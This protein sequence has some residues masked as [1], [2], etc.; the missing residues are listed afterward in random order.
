MVASGTVFGWWV[1]EQQS[2]DGKRAVQS[3]ARAE[4]L[5]LKTAH[6]YECDSDCSTRNYSTFVNVGQAFFFGFT[7]LV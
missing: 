6:T 4:I 7:S 2:P 5:A 1:R 3:G